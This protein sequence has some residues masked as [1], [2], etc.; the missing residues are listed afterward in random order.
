M[1]KSNV[2]LY[3]KPACQQCTMTER[4]MKQHGI[5]YNKIDITQ[6]EDA[7]AFVTGLG[8]MQAPVVTA[9]EDHWSGFIPDR[10]A[11]LV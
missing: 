1:K 7:Y 9:G 4:Y 3:G 2:T 11:A 6:D 8:Y 10:L 5:S